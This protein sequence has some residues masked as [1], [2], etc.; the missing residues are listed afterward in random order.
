MRVSFGK[1]LREV[2]MAKTGKQGAAMRGA[3]GPR[4]GKSVGAGGKVAKE[5]VTSDVA[6]RGVGKKAKGKPF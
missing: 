3:P 2:L 1:Q 4:I 6:K 5:Y